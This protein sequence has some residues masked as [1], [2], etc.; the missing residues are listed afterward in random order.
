MTGFR[1]LAAV[2]VLCVTTSLAG[3]AAAT[4]IKLPKELHWCEPLPSVAE[5]LGIKDTSEFGDSYRADGEYLVRGDL[6]D[7]DGNYT[8]RFDEYGDDMF[9]IEVEWRMFRSQQS[10]DQIIAK[11]TK[12]LGEGDRAVVAGATYDPDGGQMSAER[13]EHTWHDG[14]GAWDVSARQMSNEIDTVKITFNDQKRCQPEDWGKASQTAQDDTK[15]SDDSG[16]IFDYDPYSK[17][18]LANDQKTKELLAEEQKEQEEQKA[19]QD[20]EEPD[21]MAGSDDVDVDW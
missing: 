7:E 19:Q 17:D 15:K 13:T 18:P 3:A 2:M 1:P 9:L 21:W 4:G 8:V 6:F 16:D 11:L 14:D 20:T 12:T 5:K 10:W